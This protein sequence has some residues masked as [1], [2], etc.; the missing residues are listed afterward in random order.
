M[1]L[2]KLF[3][4]LCI[5]GLH[6]ENIY[7][8]EVKGYVENE[9]HSPL[10]GASIML[11]NEETTKSTVSDAEGA[12]SFTG[13]REGKY[14]LEVQYLGYQ[15]YQ[16]DL[17]ITNSMNLTI[18]MTPGVNNLEEIVVECTYGERR[19][20][21]ESHNIEVI[22]R[23]YLRQNLSGSLMQSLEGLPGVS[24]IGIGSSQSKPVIRGLGFNRLVVAEHGIKH[25]GQQWGSDHSLEL[26]QYA[27]DNVEIIKGPASL[28]YGSDA[29]A[30][31]VNV[32][33]AFVPEPYTLSGSVDLTGKSNNRMFGTSASLH[34]R[35]KSFYF[36]SRITLNDYADYR[37]PTDSVD[38]YSFRVPLHK[39]RLRNTAGNELNLHFSTGIIKP[40]WNTKFFISN[41]SSKAGFFA[42]AHGLEPR[43]VDMELYDKSDRDILHP[44]Q[45]VDHLKLV[46]RT[47]I[48]LN[49]TMVRFDLGYQ[50]NYR[51]EHSKYVSHGYM[52]PVF[53]DTLDYAPDLER[54]FDK[55]IFSGN[56]ELT[57]S[58]GSGYSI[59]TG[60][61]TELQDNDIGGRNFIIPAFQ[62]LS[63]GAFVIN[64]WIA[65]DNLVVN[66]GIRYDYGMLK[67]NKY[68][69]WFPTEGEYL[70]R[71]PSMEKEFSSISG[72][73]G[74]NYHKDDIILKINAGRSF[75]M[76]IAKELAAN[77]VN[78]HHF[79]YEKGDSTLTPEIS[80]QLDA[81]FEYNPGKYKIKLS[82]FG[83]YFPNY[84]YLNPTSQF[85]YSYGAGNQVFYYTGTSVGRAGGELSVKYD[86]LPELKAG[87]TAEYI[88]QVQ[89]NGDK[90]GFTLPFS[91]PPSALISLRYNPD[92]PDF[93]SNTHIKANYRITAEQN[94]IVPPEK[95][96]PSY[97]VFDLS[98][99]GKVKYRE[100]DINVNFKINNLFNT[101]YLNHTSYYRLIGVPEPGRNFM[102]SISIPFK[103]NTK[104]NQ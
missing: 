62:Q 32:S 84:I 45:N 87:V 41:V 30:G 75:R 36:N 65:N 6:A 17:K 39:N 100:E 58:I 49:K 88:Y 9:L 21:I 4:L 98:I 91:P 99:G 43:K 52:P 54:K 55:H 71:A 8:Y 19:N 92:L 5:A 72:A 16:R 11:Y 60:I 74:I 96:T 24:Y 12:F 64:E 61:N 90:K 94:S 27:A 79:S 42:N 103:I 95:K 33:Q 28:K 104:N 20:R 22:G 13:I 69:D 18:H 101:N 35:K 15:S 57:R 70:L 34:G 63:A 68:H 102:L 97:Q 29:I 1:K 51:E 59:T 66:A 86:I 80:Y 78:Y 77:G 89:M 25:Q 14:I 46:N 48:N 47:M 38:I 44:Y 23:D 93:M 81:D 31:V 2:L 37:V 83:N 67:I 3:C 26:D 50:H 10:P 7:S 53:P 56:L 40:N 85:D 73:A 76:P 82:P